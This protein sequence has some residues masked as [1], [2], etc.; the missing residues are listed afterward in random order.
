MSGFKNSRIFMLIIV[1]RQTGEQRENLMEEL[2]K[3][4]LRE[5][6]IYGNE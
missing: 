3:V 5:L 1:C 6:R 4:G 2:G